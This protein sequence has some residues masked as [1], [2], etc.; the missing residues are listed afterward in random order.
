MYIEQLAIFKELTPYSGQIDKNNQW[1]KLS[2]LVPWD[3]MDV[4]YQKHFDIRKRNVIKKCRLIMGLIIGQMLKKESDRGILEYF[5]ENP[6][7]Q[8]FCGQD[9]FVP[10][11]KTTIIHPSLLS[12][13]RSRLG[14]RY[15]Q[16]LEQ[17]VL[18]VLKKKRLIKGDKLILDATVFPVNITYPN[19]V[20][21][22]N[23]VRSYLCKTIL[24]V[25]NRI[26][27]ARKIRTYRRVARRVYL[28]FQKTKKKSNQFI[29]KSRKQMIQFVTRNIRQ[30]EN[31]LTEAQNQAGSLKQWHVDQITKKLIVARKVLEQQVHMAT[32]RGRSVANRIVSFH[33]PEVRPM[34]RGK[35][36]KMVEFGPKAHVA[37]VDGFAILD[38][39]QFD[40][41]HEGVRLND[42]LKKHGVRFEKQPNLVLADQLYANLKNR[43]LLK[44][45]EIEHS[46][47]H[48][49][50][51]PN[52]SKV[53]KMKK[54]NLFRKRQGQRNHIEAT[55]G[56][57]KNR[58]NL[59]KLTWSVP[60]GPKMQVHFGLI[61]ANLHRAV[62]LS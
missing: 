31:V 58:F 41:F 3:E 19:D 5:H 28:N 10:K 22:L 8:Y 30:L 60:G 51:P 61:S 36:G 49:G 55:F 44:N 33:R 7:F 14:E 38:D 40:S 16:K 47:R 50:R 24:E 26:D 34:V 18:N 6:Y 4:L 48:L 1:I 17:E 25:K 29:R 9:V 27:P 2:K 21:L 37:L 32:T 42:S 45:C 53:V 20:K 13:R 54:Q 11:L 15:A 52:E 57:L 23:T 56:H 59:D 35:E 46:F 39:F 12:K 62:A 43:K